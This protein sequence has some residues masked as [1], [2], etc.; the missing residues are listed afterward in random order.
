MSASES[1]YCSRTMHSGL[2]VAQVDLVLQRHGVLGPHD[3]HGLNGQALEFLEL[4][5]M[6][7]EGP[8]VKH[9]Y[10]AI[11]AAAT[12]LGAPASVTVA[13]GEV[14]ADVREG[15]LA[16]AVEAGLQVMAAM[17]SED[18]TVAC[19]PKGSTMRTGL[20]PS[21]QRGRQR[22]SR[23]PAG[24]DRPAADACDRRLRRTA[25]TKL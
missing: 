9:D 25:D 22:H 11:D 18:V 19:G 23:R 7:Q 10:Q 1:R 8:L 20:R 16:M 4:V 5:L 24:A 17:M 21:W 6:K 12:A 3:V 15:L 14:T 2:I 13:I